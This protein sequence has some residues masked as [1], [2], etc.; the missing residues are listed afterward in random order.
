MQACTYVDERG[1]EYLALVTRI[2]PVEDEGAKPTVSVAFVNEDGIE[3]MHGAA[4]SRRSGVPHK[5]QVPE[6][7]S[8]DD[9]EYGSYVP[10]AYWDDRRKL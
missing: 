8:E 9:E 7:P 1:N 4:L 10:Q 5:S 3:D 6:P 2:D